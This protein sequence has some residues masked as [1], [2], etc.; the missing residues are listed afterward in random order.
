MMNLIILIAGCF[1]D[2]ASAFYIFVPIMLP[3][4]HELGVDP[5]VFG[6]FMTVNL[7]IGMAT[8]PIGLDIFMASNVSGVPLKE[9]SVKVLPF[10]AVSVLALML[11]TLIPEI[12]LWLPNLIGMK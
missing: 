6:V 7:A 2:A 11:I 1:I 3:I 10:V 8:P 4:I 5:I 12:S 9:I